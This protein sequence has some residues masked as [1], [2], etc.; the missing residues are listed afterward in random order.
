MAQEGNTAFQ[1]V[2][3]MARPAESIK[4]LPWCVS[5]ADPSHYISEALAHPTES[6]PP[7][8][9]LLADLPFVGTP[10]VGQPF[11]KFLAIS[12]QKKQGCSSSSSLNHHPSKGT[13]FNSQEV[14]AR[15]EHSSTQGNKNMP[16]LVPEAEPS[17]EQQEQEPASTPSSPT[18][19]MVDRNDETAAESSESTGDQ[20]S[21]DSDLPREN[22]ADSD[23]DTASSNCITCS[24][25]DEVPI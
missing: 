15:S 17:S 11:A 6:P 1:E 19:A 20:A 3:A 7:M 23:M 13:C 14:K 12:T 18:M 9:P 25:T 22:V 16:E 21:S 2:F 4:L 24:D 10:P 5:S 8:T